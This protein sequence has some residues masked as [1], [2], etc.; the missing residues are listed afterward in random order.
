MN[1]KLK[2]NAYN[3]AL[4]K[5]LI[6]DANGKMFL[7]SDD[8]W[9]AD[10]CQARPFP[11]TISAMEYCAHYNLHD[12]RVVLKFGAARFDVALQP[13]CFPW[14][15]PDWVRERS[16]LPRQADRRRL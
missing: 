10:A 1:L 11:D 7:L 8:V 12:V 2:A 13:R 5:I 6:Q 14:M 9:T 3:E 15:K 16:N 4:M